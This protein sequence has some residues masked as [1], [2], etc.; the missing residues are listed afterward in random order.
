MPICLNLS[1]SDIRRI[2]CTGGT[3]L[4]EWSK[5]RW[6]TDEGTDTSL[7]KKQLHCK[8]KGN[9]SWLLLNAHEFLVQLDHRTKGF[10]V[11][12]DSNHDLLWQP[13]PPRIERSMRHLN[14]TYNAERSLSVTWLNMNLTCIQKRRTSFLR[15]YARRWGTLLLQVFILVR[16]KWWPWNASRTSGTREQLVFMPSIRVMK[17]ALRPISNKTRAFEIFFKKQ[18]MEQTT[19]YALHPLG[20]APLFDKRSDKREKKFARLS[21]LLTIIVKAN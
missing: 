8:L 15:A 4:F 18:H 5:K 10:F 16:Q 9:E 3:F 12:I 14:Q 13:P 6:N 7:R 19:F 17:S 20:I 1:R 2:P 11:V 21:R